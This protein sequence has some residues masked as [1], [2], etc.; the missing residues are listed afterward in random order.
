[1]DTFARD[2]EIRAR[3]IPISAKRDEIMRAAPPC[4]RCIYG[5]IVQ[6]DGAECEHLVHWR[7]LEYDAAAAKWRGQRDRVTVRE[8]RSQNGI[9]GPEGRLFEPYGFFRNF[10]RALAALRLRHAP[11]TLYIR[12][13]VGL[14]SLGVGLAVLSTFV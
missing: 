5:P 4:D 3:L 1:M 6:K 7:N 13:M 11:E 2:R 12:F 10:V 14:A 8:A 9:C